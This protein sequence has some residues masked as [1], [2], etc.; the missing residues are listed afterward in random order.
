MILVLVD[1]HNLG[2]NVFAS[3]YV[4]SSK[5][6]EWTWIEA[7]RELHMK[8]AIEDIPISYKSPRDKTRK[9][10]VKKHE[11]QKIGLILGAL[12]RLEVH[13]T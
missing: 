4:Y 5:D 11:E 2:T 1:K 6:V 8:K 10:Q 7:L 12:D 3:V 9:A 13:Q